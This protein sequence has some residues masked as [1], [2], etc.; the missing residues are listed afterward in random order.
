M[1]SPLATSVNF[2][3]Q[4]SVPSK[5]PLLLKILVPFFLNS[6]LSFSFLFLL[7]LY[8]FSCQIFFTVGHFAHKHLQ[9]YSKSDS[10]CYFSSIIFRTEKEIGVEKKLYLFSFCSHLKIL[11]ASIIPP[12]LLGGNRNARFC[13]QTIK[14]MRP[15]CNWILP[16]GFLTQ[17]YPFWFKTSERN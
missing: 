14:Y 13:I 11:S 7:P 8:L 10:K 15:R 9:N 2:Q 5:A 3:L 17:Y 4:K 6:S 16:Q 12:A 1:E